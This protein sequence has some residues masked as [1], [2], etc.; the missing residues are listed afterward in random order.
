MYWK[1][2]SEDKYENKKDLNSLLTR[3]NT[4]GRSDLQ[5]FNLVLERYLEESL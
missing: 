3:L 5:V 4:P 1:L 2:Q